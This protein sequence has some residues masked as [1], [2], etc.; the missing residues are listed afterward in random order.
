MVEENWVELAI[1]EEVSPEVPVV[2]ENAIA[3]KSVQEN[4]NNAYWNKFVTIKKGEEAVVVKTEV[5]K[6][7]I[8]EEKPVWDLFVNYDSEFHKNQKTI[9]QKI[10]MFKMMPKTSVWFVSLLI[11]ITLCWIWI[12]MKIDPKTHSIENYKANVLAVF[13]IKVERKVVTWNTPLWVNGKTW[14]WISN[15][16]VLNNTWSWIIGSWAI[17]EKEEILVKEKWLTIRPDLITNADWS[18]SYMY[19]WKV[20]TKDELQIQLKLEVK[21]EV[22]KKTKD[23]LN[24]IYIPWKQ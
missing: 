5:K 18:I 2:E 20:Y 12:M 24:K 11:V 21:N 4:E 15:S 16:W 23:Y 10:R 6:E 13:W 19:N 9:L 3:S 8:I 17:D 22:H 14:T 1:T 7:E